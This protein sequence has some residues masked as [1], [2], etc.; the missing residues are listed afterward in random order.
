MW[1]SPTN[2]Q[3]HCNDREGLSSIPGSQISNCYTL[4]SMR[5]GLRRAAVFY[6]ESPAN[7]SEI[8][9]VRAASRREALIDHIHRLH[10]RSSRLGSREDTVWTQMIRLIVSLRSATI[11]TIQAITTWQ[12]QYTKR[13]RLTLFGT[14]YVLEMVSRTDFL[15]SLKLR[16]GLGFQIC[17][18]IVFVLPMSNSRGMR[19]L[20]VDKELHDALTAWSQPPMEEMR[21]AFRQLSHVLPPEMHRR[22]VWLEDWMAKSVDAS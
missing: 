8:A 4:H 1:K 22:I 14:D 2:P 10:L 7:D 9:V 11:E 6:Q 5:R 13:R 21:E 3:P 18:G 15:A 16:H 12:R 20:G 17:R 19:Q